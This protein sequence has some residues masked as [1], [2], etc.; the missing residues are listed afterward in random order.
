[1]ALLLD[2]ETLDALEAA[3]ASLRELSSAGRFVKRGN[4]HLTLA[5]LG[6]V[7]RSRIDELKQVLTAVVRETSRCEAADQQSSHQP[8]T[9]LTLTGTGRFKQRK[10]STCWIG[11]EPTLWL[12]ETHD[13]LV[14]A[15]LEAGFQVDDKPFKP[16]ITLGRNV[17]LNEG[18]NLEQWQVDSLPR[19]THVNAI[20]LMESSIQENRLTYVSLHEQ[21]FAGQS[22]QNL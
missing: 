10:G 18:V 12:A 19:A 14:A 21:T 5:F 16:H 13:K 1:M 2:E 3:V 9:P 22:F 6:Q 8:G 20:H 4:L 11:I 15:L 17:V 7:E